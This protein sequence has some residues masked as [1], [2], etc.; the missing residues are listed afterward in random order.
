MTAETTTSVP[1]GRDTRNSWFARIQAGIIGGVMATIFAI[2]HATLITG[3]VA[4]E[5]TFAMIS[6]AL[7]GTA[8]LCVFLGS[9]SQFKGVIP[10]TQDVPCAALG[11]ILVAILS[12]RSG[13]GPVSAGVGATGGASVALAEVVVLCL[14]A[15]ITMGLATLLFGS[16]RLATLMRYAPRPVLAGFLAGTGYIVILGAL[17]MCLGTTVTPQSLVLLAEGG[18][19]IKLAVAL[20]VCGALL[21]LNR[22][23]SANLA[24]AGALVAGV[25]LFHLTALLTGTPLSAL[26]EAGWFAQV[27]DKGG[28][29]P[30]LSLADLRTIDPWLILNQLFAL[31]TLVL[32]ATAALLVYSSAIEAN[33]RQD[34]DLD[35]EL[36]TLGVANLVTTGLGGMMGYH[37]AVTTLSVSR[38]ARPHRAISF[39][40]GGF[41]LMVFLFGDNVLSTLPL[42]VFA[43][44]MLWVGV[45]FLR[46]FLLREMRITPRGEAVL[47]ATVFLA[48][49]L[50]GLFEGTIFGIAA[51]CGLFIVN[52]SR[53]DPVRAALS[54][55]LFHSARERDTRDLRVLQRH[56]AEILVL[57]LQ[58]Y[59][60]FGTA[61]QVR[62]R[63][64][65]LSRAGGV[66][67]IVLDFEA[68]TGIDAT[69]ADSFSRLADDLPEGI[70]HVTVTGMSEQVAGV[71]ERA[72]PG[73][74]GTSR[75]ATAPDLNGAL[76]DYEAR[77]LQTH[78]GA[79]GAPVEGDLH[80]ILTDLLG[81]GAFATQLQGYLS[82][83]DAAAGELVI[84]QGEEAADIYLLEQGQV[85]VR[86]G[87]LGAERAVRRL[88]PGAILGEISYY[89]GTRRTSTIRAVTSA[90]LWRLSAD[91]AALMLSDAPELSSRLHHAIAAMLA[92]RVN[93]NTRLIQMLQM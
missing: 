46:D 50:F 34:F 56:G 63:I 44:F 60:F 82:P 85:E 81:D 26:A 64:K 24:L 53:L 74:G 89:R 77:V 57:K 47:T 43:G 37:S 9:L 3:A 39:V 18:V 73:T 69:A 5:A 10:I 6:M 8:L 31:V 83:V 55:D 23:V 65:A 62:A 7:F 42:P 28:S 80:Q 66:Q 21:V 71:F 19:Q 84:T 2:A 76:E 78:P 17:G 12:D 61:Y 14:V 29:W 59:V 15:G 4:P 93:A 38:V 33:S 35:R 51:G 48:I 40:A 88:G 49:A 70:A 54:G 13:L 16:F 86:V 25:G 45:E 87:P 1:K 52:Y 27:P 58:G 30:P 67:Y 75:F 36:R 90:R 20:A 68:V 11:A 22:Y 91:E 32:L 92:E 79:A 41:V 72:G